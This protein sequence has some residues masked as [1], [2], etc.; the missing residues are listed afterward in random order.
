[1]RKPPLLTTKPVGLPPKIVRRLAGWSRATVYRRMHDG[2]LPLLKIG[3][4]K[5]VSTARFEEMIGREITLAEINAALDAE[6]T[7][8]EA[9]KA[10]QRQRVSAAP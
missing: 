4:R 5:H 6:T 3:G 10:H 7:A 9:K 2:S 8:Y 1:M